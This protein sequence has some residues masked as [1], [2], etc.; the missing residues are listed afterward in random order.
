MRMEAA[1]KPEAAEITETARAHKRQKTWQIL[2]P[3]ILTSVVILAGFVLLLWQAGAQSGL[4]T[5][6]GQIAAIVA[7]LPWMMLFIIN[8]VLLIVL[9]VLTS[10]LYRAIP[11]ASLSVLKALIQVNQRTRSLANASVQPVLNLRQ[12]AAKLDR[13]ARSLTTNLTKEE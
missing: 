9:I 8:L 11:G 1:P 3:V 10:K 2:V 12:G 4:I 13:L 5:Q 6:R 7:V